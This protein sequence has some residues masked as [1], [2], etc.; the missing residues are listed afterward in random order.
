MDVRRLTHEQVLQLIRSSPES[1]DLVIHPRKFRAHRNSGSNFDE[2]EGAVAAAAAEAAPGASQLSQDT[3]PAVVAQPAEAAAPQVVELPAVSHE[4]A[5]HSAAAVAPATVVESQQAEDTVSSQ[6]AKVEQISGTAEVVV[7][8][9]SGAATADPVV[10]APAVMEEASAPAPE[11]RGVDEAVGDDDVIRPSDTVTDAVQTDDALE[12]VVAVSVAAEA[13]TSAAAETV[14]APQLTETE[15]AQSTAVEEL[16]DEP[17]PAEVRV[18]IMPAIVHHAEPEHHEAQSHAPGEVEIPKSPLAA[19]H[20]R[21]VDHP[22]P[23]MF[24]GEQSADA[25]PQRR[26]SN[27][28]NLTPNE[29]AVERQKVG[30]NERDNCYT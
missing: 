7:E 1:L 28:F 4:V 5:V 27:D 24:P 18:A 17:Q 26:D 10:E 20:L 30:Q 29:T 6:P 9:S 13:Q 11:H 3:T 23:D 2:A 12:G 16:A 21:H 22:P 15:P 14:E 8:G 25:K 19:A